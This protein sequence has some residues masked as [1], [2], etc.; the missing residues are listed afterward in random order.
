MHKQIEHLVGAVLDLDTNHLVENLD[1]AEVRRNTVQF[2]GLMALLGIVI[3]FMQSLRVG[4]LDVAFVIVGFVWA[5]FYLAAG[6]IVYFLNPTKIWCIRITL[7]I[8]V[9]EGAIAI[10]RW[11]IYKDPSPGGDA[12]IGVLIGLTLGALLLPWTPRQTIALS[13]LWIVG[14]GLA[15]IVNKH[16]EDFSNLGAIFAYIVVT[17]PGMM[18]SFFRSTR[19]QDQFELHFIKTRYEEVREELQAAKNIHERGFPKPKSSGEIRFTYAYRP[20]SQIGGDS[21][22]ASIEQPGETTSP[23][24]LVLYDVTGHGLSA[25]LTANRLQGELMR[26][27]GEDPTVDP[28]ELLTQLDRYVCL[29]LGDSAVL[30]SAVAFNA[31]PVKGTIRIANAGHPAPILRT[32]RGTIQRFESTSP[33]LGVGMGTENKPIVEEHPFL[34][35]DSL[36]AYTDGVSEAVDQE[37][38]LYTTQGVERVLNEDWTEQ[39]ERWPEKILTDVEKRRAGSASD[40]ILIVELYRA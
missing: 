40:D 4:P 23:L 20:M 8:I 36:I 15:L 28:G 9:A 33:V 7:L 18:I 24:T 25:A 10:V 2:L 13:V 1:T 19:L 6:A 21:I 22:F 16:A 39:Q 31:D 12:V 27:M 14:S 34:Q 37:G 30:V 17:I 32:A 26:I 5:G 38:E 3:I 29:T 35:G 11:V